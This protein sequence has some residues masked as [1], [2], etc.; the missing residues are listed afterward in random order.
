RGVRKGDAVAVFA[1]RSAPT[2]VA[3]LG[4]LKAG[5]AVVMLDPAH[6]A[7]RLR[8]CLEEARPRAVVAVA[9]AGPIP[10]EVARLAHDLGAPTLEVGSGADADAENGAAFAGVTVGP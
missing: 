8:L 5:G 3:I 9:A 2:V 6:P 7:A 10:E 4:V 1:H